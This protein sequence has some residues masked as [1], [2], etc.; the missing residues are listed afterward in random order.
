MRKMAKRG[1]RATGQRVTPPNQ[2]APAATCFQQW[3][4]RANGTEA[5]AGGLAAPT[6]SSWSKQPSEVGLPLRLQGKMG[7]GC[8]GN[9]PGVQHSVLLCCRPP[10][11]PQPE[12]SRHQSSLFPAPI[13][14]P[15][16]T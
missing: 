15:P 4:E 3:W 11:A 2:N 12:G 5:A 8:I 9:S 14:S 1:A 13:S 7:T 16:P 10:L 6:S